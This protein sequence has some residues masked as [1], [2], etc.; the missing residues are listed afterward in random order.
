MES[1]ESDDPAALNPLNDPDFAQILWELY[2]RNGRYWFA[3][4]ITQDP[5][6]Q[7]KSVEAGRVHRLFIGLHETFSRL[8]VYTG[9]LESGRKKYQQLRELF[10]VLGADTAEAEDAAT[11]ALQLRFSK[12]GQQLTMKEFESA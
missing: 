4:S 10:G 7:E 6:A 3:F 12:E 8:Y 2:D 11:P 5:D 1:A 9:E